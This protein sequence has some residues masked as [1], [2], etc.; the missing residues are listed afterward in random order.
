MKVVITAAAK[1]DLTEIADYIRPHNLGRAASFVEEL[2]DHC[3][4]LA[5]CLSAIRSFPAL[6]ATASA[7]AFTRTI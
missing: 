2:L 7:G 6:N 5:D 4:T 3:Q 1:R